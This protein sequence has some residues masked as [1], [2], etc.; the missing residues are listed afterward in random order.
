MYHG[1]ASTLLPLI[2]R[3]GLRYVAENRL[4][5]ALIL[6]SD[7][8]VFVPSSRDEPGHVYVAAKWQSA[9]NYAVNRAAYLNAKPR[10][11]F[12]W[13]P[14]NEFHGA[15]PDYVCPAGKRGDLYLPGSIPVILQVDVGGLDAVQD[16]NDRLAHRIRSHVSPDRLRVIWEGKSLEVKSRM[17]SRIAVCATKVPGDSR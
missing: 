13:A 12:E 17:V 4:H 8:S 11:V 16:P 5:V 2:L 1:T 10:T 15:D 9:M 6:E 14:Y 7:K 3:N